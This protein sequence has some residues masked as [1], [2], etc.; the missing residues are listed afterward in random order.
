MDYKVD[1]VT[2]L[3]NTN[4]EA[5]RASSKDENGMRADDVAL[6]K[7]RELNVVIG[8]ARDPLYRPFKWQR[9]LR[10]EQV[11]ALANIVEY[12]LIDGNGDI[13]P[14]PL[15]HN[16]D[17]LPDA[18]IG[19]TTETFKLVRFGNKFQ[20]TD[21]EMA[22]AA[23]LGESLS[24]RKAMH[25]RRAW[26]E[27]LDQTCASG[28]VNGGISLIGLGNQPGVTLEPALPKTGGNLNWSVANTPT[29][30]EIL[31]DLHN[32][33]NRIELQSNENHTCDLI[34]LPLAE[35]QILASTRIADTQETVMQRWNNEW[36][37]RRQGMG[38]GRLEVWNR[39][40]NLNAAG[41][42]ARLVGM[43]SKD[44]DVAALLMAD[45]YGVKYVEKKAWQ[46][47]AYA[48]GRF[49]GVRVLDTSGI[50]YMDLDVQP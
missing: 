16:P 3:L 4:G 1:A 25:Q 30:Q 2:G 46:T 8:A 50:V 24:T 17:D 29:A 21:E 42:A 20:Y 11:P 35:F 28:Y 49:G 43:D 39:F 37:A 10:V 15:V 9:I 31:Q 22:R 23:L 18:S 38:P 36:A 48:T 40:S 33:C 45:P 13:Q 5:F 12:D 27:L 7:E 6:A 32:I 44:P 19:R 26:E 47:T 34:I 41:N 14:I